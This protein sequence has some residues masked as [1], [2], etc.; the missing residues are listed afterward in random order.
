MAVPLPGWFAAEQDAPDRRPAARRRPWA[1]DRHALRREAPERQGPYRDRERVEAA[2]APGGRGRCEPAGGGRRAADPRPARARGRGS[3]GCTCA[4]RSARSA[5]RRWLP[6]STTSATSSWPTRRV[7]DGHQR[8]LRQARGLHEGG[9]GRRAR[10]PRLPRA[11]ERRVADAARDDRPRTGGCCSWRRT[12]RRASP[13]T[14]PRS[15]ASP[16]TRPT[17][18][19]APGSSRIRTASPETCEP[20]RGPE[21]APLFLVNHWVSTDPAPRPSDATKVNA[22]EPLLRRMRECERVRDHLPNLVAVN[23][24]RRG[25]RVRS[26]GRAQRRALGPRRPA[27]VGREDLAGGQ[28]R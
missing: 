1:P 22:R 16:R 15:R 12:S 9:R 11:R 7:R 26:G 18:S 8:G 28:R 24:Y 19:P 3:A 10:R 25:R 5:R 13:G 27:G 4:T 23:F 14:T 6:C 17:R 21:G 20:N 2:P